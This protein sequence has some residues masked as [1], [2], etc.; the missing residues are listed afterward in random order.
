MND[1]PLNRRV[2]ALAA[3]EGVALEIRT[4]PEGTR[5]ADEAARA[6]GVPV[7][8]IVKSLV[9]LAGERPVM[10]L[11]AGGRRANEQAL[12]RHF[13]EAIRRAPPEVVRRAT[14]AAIGGV[15]PFG[16]PEA[17]PTAMDPALFTHA[18]VWCAAG[19]PDTV[20]PIAPLDLLRLTGAAVLPEDGEIS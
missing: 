3:R 10:V 9:F 17:L 8:A 11:V 14:G 7:G 18:V 2:S 12:G 19:T 4:F 1:H 6:V 13:G 20:F 5:T 15:P 16:H